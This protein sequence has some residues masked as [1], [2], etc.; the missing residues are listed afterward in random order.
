MFFGILYGCYGCQK[1]GAWAV[2]GIKCDYYNHYNLVDVVFLRF[3]MTTITTLRKQLY[4]GVSWIDP[5]ELGW[6]CKAILNWGGLCMWIG[7][8][9]MGD[10]FQLRLCVWW[11]CC[12][13]S[14][15]PQGPSLRL[16]DSSEMSSKKDSRRSILASFVFTYP[17]F[18][19]GNGKFPIYID[20]LAPTH[21]NIEYQMA[22]LV[23]YCIPFTIKHRNYVGKSSERGTSK[24]QI[25]F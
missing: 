24:V 23:H 4:V 18:Q 13:K 15:L 14:Q 6:F 19:S 1:C 16:A 9:S 12:Q 5:Y 11:D 20:N 21:R 10:P 22:P 7:I 3:I 17:P 8:F 2:S 25:H